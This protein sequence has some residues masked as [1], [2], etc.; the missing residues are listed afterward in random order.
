MP[1][2]PN[3]LLKGDLVRFNKH[4]SSNGTND[5]PL[6]GLVGVVLHVEQLAND[7]VYWVTGDMDVLIDTLEAN[8]ESRR[9]LTE[10]EVEDLKDQYS[11]PENPSLFV[12][13]EV[14]DES[15]DRL[16]FPKVRRSAR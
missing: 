2:K 10:E 9:K 13:D 5:S 12:I 11:D 7:T 8:G 3:R 14:L 15:L 4:C 1:A 6:R 16:T